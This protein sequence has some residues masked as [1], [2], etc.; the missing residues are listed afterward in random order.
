MIDG[1]TKAVLTVIAVTLVWLA[2][3]N[4]IP[5]ADAAR[6][7]PQAVFLAQI[8]QGAAKCIAGH[9]TVFWGDTGPCIAGW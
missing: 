6:H 9:V 8:S 5:G 2:V 4:S 3:Q 1:Y 7:E